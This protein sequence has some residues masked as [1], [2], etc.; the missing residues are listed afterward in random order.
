MKRC[1]I[2]NRGEIACR[3][4][5]AAKK[6]GWL[7]GIISTPA[8]SDSLVR[9]LADEVL[10]VSSFLNAEEIVKAAKSWKADFLHP[11]YG[12]LS[13]NADFA[14][15]VEKAGI[16]F[17]G[18]TP[19]NMTAM[20]GKESSKKIANLHN[21]PTLNALLSHELKDLAESKW[22]GELA[23]RNITSPYLV[24]ASGGG[25]GKGMRVV[26]K[27]SELPAQLKRASE[28]AA[29]S[30]NDPTVFVERYLV[31]PRHI[32]IQVFGDGKGSGV[33]L[34]ERE[35][36]LQRRHQKVVEEAPSSVVNPALRKKMGE[37]ALS[38]VAAVKYRGAG[39]IEFLLDN[40]NNYFFLE[41]N[42]RLQVEHPVTEQVFEVDLV[43]AQFDLAEGK[44]PFS[45]KKNFEP[46]GVSFEARILAE[47]PSSGFMPTPG[48]LSL[49]REPQTARVDSG[50]KEGGRVNA[51][52]DSLIAKLIVW[53]PTREV[54]TEGL[55]KALE[56]FVIHGCKTNIS[57][58]RNLVGHPDFAAGKLS[59]HWIQDNQEALFKSRLSQ[60]LTDLFKKENFLTELS[61]KL[62][63]IEGRQNPYTQI[64]AGL[65]LNQEEV[66]LYTLNRANEFYLEFNEQTFKIT[67]SRVGYTDI[68]VTL[69]G[70]TF[71]VPCPLRTKMESLNA[72][73]IGSELKSPMAGKVLEVYVK[74]SQLL[75]EGELAFVIES[76]KMQLE[77]RAGKKGK[78]KDVFV[79]KGQSLAGPDV[80]ATLEEC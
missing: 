11:G 56:E 41:M 32:E 22:E 2:A 80:L 40:E 6:R 16:A 24:K 25:G 73:E 12:F 58:L 79:T 34:G 28:E 61:L 37:S 67:A 49:Y 18:P 54:A 75:S 47:D 78:V 43:D 17:V 46:K 23:A 9:Q 59:T 63:R 29:A 74:P 13:E 7:V 1:V 72:A 66:Y 45:E 57:F 42:T 55:K 26:E 35:C 30:F 36:S 5:R 33:Y 19:E 31:A 76:M 62:S 71:V 52:F 51:D 60:P 77:V 69:E 4:L 15:L 3:I 68:A 44:W 38:L 21:V 20:G 65:K 39:T 27:F 53:G 48:P 10:E 64:L 8:D 50:V 70:E 14:S